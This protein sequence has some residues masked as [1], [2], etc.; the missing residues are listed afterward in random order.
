MNSY[1][2]IA[3]AALMLAASGTVATANPDQP[4]IDTCIDALMASGKAGAAGGTVLGSRFSQA[5]TEVLL[6]D[7]SGLVWRCIAYS[8]G[9]VGVLEEASADAAEAAR[10][11]PTASDAQEAVRFDAGATSAVLTRS[12]GPGDAS[13]Y[14]LGAREG[15]FLRVRVTPHSGEMYYLIRNPDNSLLLDGMG[16]ETEYYGQLWQSG[17]HVVEVVNQTSENVTY[18]VSFA[19]E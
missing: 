4:A 9:S 10:S 3:A 5:G 6:E 18:D 11:A 12:L 15:Q 1:K 7:G 2:S 16:T 19:I 8:D 14:V 13:Q 17:D